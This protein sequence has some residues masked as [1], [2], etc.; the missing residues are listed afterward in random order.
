M[1]IRTKTTEYEITPDVSNYLDERIASLEKLLGADANTAR[2]E[3][4][5]GR[6]A[7]G[8][9]HG[10]YLWFAEFQIVQPGLDRIVTRNNEPTIN[11]AI[12]AA[13]DEIAPQTPQYKKAPVCDS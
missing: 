6:A 9:R 7:G 11:A 10:E 13:K 2:L 8:Q 5:V 3:V 4:E 12:D 1:D